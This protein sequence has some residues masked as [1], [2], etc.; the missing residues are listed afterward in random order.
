M[1]FDLFYKVIFWKYGQSAV[2]FF[3]FVVKFGLFCCC[4]CVCT[5]GRQAS[6]PSRHSFYSVGVSAAPN[7]SDPVRSYVPNRHI[8]TILLVIWSERRQCLILSHNIGNCILHIKNGKFVSKY[9]RE[10]IILICR[11][12]WI[13]TGN[14]LSFLSHLR[15]NISQ[16]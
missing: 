15:R 14:I 13:R 9:K 4:V 6:K 5:V 12:V 2:I 3:L 11:K 7:S 16:F 1:W 10:F 8:P